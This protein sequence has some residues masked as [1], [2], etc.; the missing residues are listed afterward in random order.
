MIGPGSYQSMKNSKIKGGLAYKPICGVKGDLKD[1]YYVGQILV[2]VSPEKNLRKTDSAWVKS[3]ASRPTS[4][5]VLASVIKNPQTV[6]LRRINTA[7]KLSREKAP[8]P[9]P[10]RMLFLG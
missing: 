10:A 4:A 5:S 9:P 7:K 1:C 3:N 8:T 2:S 6:S